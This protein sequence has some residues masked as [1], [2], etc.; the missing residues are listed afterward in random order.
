MLTKAL[1]LKSVRHMQNKTWKEE[2]DLV[3]KKG[4]SE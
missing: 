1:Q 2:R 4:V 3:G